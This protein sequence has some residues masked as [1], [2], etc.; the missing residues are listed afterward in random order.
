MEKYLF[1]Q[2]TADMK[3]Q[4]FGKTIEECFENASYAFVEII[5]KDKIKP[6]VKKN[7]KVK[8]RDFENLL[9]NFLEEFLFLID[10]ENLILSKISNIKIDK[11]KFELSA[12]ISCDNIKKYK[13]MTDIKAITYNEL[14]VRN[15]KGK[16]ICQVVVDV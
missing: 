16:W 14:F 12:D 6:L 7:I 4:A 15:E 3:F 10:S 13:T 2:H 8:G 5:T 11:N 1:I 9:Y